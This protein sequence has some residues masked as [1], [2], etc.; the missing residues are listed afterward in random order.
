MKCLFQGPQLAN[1][2]S[3]HYLLRT[4]RR[5]GD[6]VKIVFKVDWVTRRELKPGLLTA[7]R[8]L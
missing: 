6:A 3:P 1:L 4:E 8:T 5:V 7:K 2:I